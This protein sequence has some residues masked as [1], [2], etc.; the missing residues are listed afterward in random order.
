MSYKDETVLRELYVEQDLSMAQVADRLGC[1]TDTVS[2]WVNKF[3]IDTGKLTN[4]QRSAITLSNYQHQ[5]V[6][7]VLMGDGCIQR[8]GN[9]S[10]NPYFV[11]SMANEEFI[12]WLAGELGDIVASVKE[13]TGVYAENLKNTQFTL[14]TYSHPVF[15]NYAD[16]YTDG[17]KRWPLDEP[18]TPLELKMLYVT[19][20]SPVKHPEQWA[21]KIS[22][23][24][25]SDRKESVANMF[26][27]EFGID[28]SW[29]SSDKNT[30]G[31][32][33]I[34]S[35]YSDIMWEQEPVPGFNYKWPEVT[36]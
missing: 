10:H 34:P 33:Y 12:R 16:W 2:R 27:R 8:R 36:Q 20:G 32:I 24:N 15:R 13:R 11:V 1:S 3:G 29:H 26:H 19:D 7:G 35:E 14:K 6:K 18:M 22:A 28:I 9:R 23:I 21:F 5:L 30:K 31:T 25:E 4:E 17:Q